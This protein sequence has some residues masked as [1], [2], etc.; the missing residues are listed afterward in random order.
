MVKTLKAF[1]VVAGIVSF[2]FCTSAGLQTIN[3]EN[4]PEWVTG[5]GVFF[6][7]IAFFAGPLVIIVALNAPDS[8]AQPIKTKQIK[9]T[10]TRSQTRSTAKPAAKPKTENETGAPRIYVGNI[11]PEASETDIKTAFSGFGDI[12]EV[13][14]IKDRAG[15]SKGYAFVEMLEMADAKNAIESLNGKDLGGRVLKVNLAKTK[16]NGPRRPRRPSN[17]R[18]P[19]EPRKDAQMVDWDA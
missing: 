10:T 17:P 3:L 11:S 13:R 9:K 18:P 6:I 12:K 7:G 5:L 4:A 19:R 8:A 16:P 14:V 15:K 1:G 2:L